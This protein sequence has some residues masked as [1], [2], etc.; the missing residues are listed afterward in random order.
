MQKFLLIVKLELQ[1]VEAGG[2]TGYDTDGTVRYSAPGGVADVTI[3]GGTVKSISGNGS[4]IGG[5]GR[6][7]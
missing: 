3:T 6:R 1:L 4:S 2:G 7:W 5:G